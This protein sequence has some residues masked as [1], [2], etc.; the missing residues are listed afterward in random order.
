MG[1]NIHGASNNF[2]GGTVPGA[3]N[4]ISGGFSGSP[5]VRLD[6]G[7]S[8][9]R[10]QGNLIGTD[11]TGTVDLGNGEHGVMIDGASNNLIGG[12][13][14]GA[15]NVI[16]G[17]GVPGDVAHGIA[18][19][20]FEGP[21]TTNV[22][23][24]NRIGT[25]AAGTVALRNEGAGIQIQGAGVTGNTVGGTT[26]AARNLLSGN[27]FDGVGISDG[28]AGNVVQGNLIGTDVTGSAG[29]GNGTIGVSI[30]SAPNNF[31][32]GTDP[33]AGNVIS[34]NQVGVVISGQTAVANAILGNRIFS[35]AG[36]GIDLGEDGVTANDD[37]D[38]DTGANALQNYPEIAGA[39]QN[40]GVITVTGTL[41]SAPNQ[42]YR[43]DF[44][45]NESC[46]D[47]TFG[48]GEELIASR[49]LETDSGGDAQFTF[50]LDVES[51]G[52]N[53]TATAT[54]ALNNTSEFSGCVGVTIP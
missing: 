30:D 1:V 8:G 13:D 37:G 45:M 36:L 49:I 32:G 14:L 16:S 3:G 28:A 31:L 19:Y 21:S 27:F 6:G 35:N 10:V 40:G 38:F 11:V 22:I 42:S 26:A 34:D 15:G 43:L 2:L 29:L 23:Q 12:T 52:G 50:F 9:N 54:D 17:N 20:S 51:S 53:L 18:V 7:A 47:S 5:G 44:F 4:V 48:E 33:G 46:D 39:V 41:N 25:N 24:G